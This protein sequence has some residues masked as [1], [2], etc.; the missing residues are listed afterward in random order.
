[1]SYCINPACYRQNADESATCQHCGSSLILN[2]HYRVQHRLNHDDRR[3]TD[4]YEVIHLE[5]ASTHILK[6]LTR[7]APKLI[8]LFHREAQ[9]LET[10]SYPN[11]PSVDIDGYFRY[12]PSNS[13]EALP[14]L[15]IEKIEGV[16]LSE[17][18]ASGRILSAEM[19]VDW[20]QQM[21]EILHYL[22]GQ[23]FI[24][25]DIK[26][27]NIILRPNGQLAL[28]DFGAVRNC[29]SSTYQLKVSTPLI[30][31]SLPVDSEITALV[32]PGYTPPE[33]ILGRAVQ[34]S[35]FFALGRTLVHLCT[36]LSPVHLIS[37]TN[38]NLLDWHPHAKHLDP[39][40]VKYL[41]ELM[42]PSVLKRPKSSEE[43]LGFLRLRLPAQRKWS[44]LAKSKLFRFVC[45]FLT[46]LLLISGLHFAQRAFAD[47]AF[48]TGLKQL[49]SNRLSEA[50]SNFERS[51]SLYPTEDAYINLGYLCERTQDINCVRNS[52]NKAISLNPQSTAAYF[53][54]GSVY[55]DEWDYKSAIAFYRKAVAVSQH[56]APAPLNNLSR[57][58][59]LQGNYIEAKSLVDSALKLKLSEP[60]T[61]RP[62]LLKNLGWIYFKEKKYAE[63]KKI[64]N[65]SIDLSFNL[66]SSHCL[67]AQV[68]EVQ[69]QPANSEWRYC[70][71]IES[72]DTKNI[73]VFQWRSLFINRT[74]SPL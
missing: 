33:Q 44:K 47:N 40:L 74:L 20:L 30:N 39:P 27:S 3:M 59:I 60:K 53:N 2:H 56:T 67:L 14:C 71:T 69:K 57:L 55:E 54:L 32:T 21:V 70:L 35:D 9:V 22:H 4:V 10:L 42:Q 6:V 15:I 72:E 36:G 48:I 11:I 50:Q 52:Y 13:T 8:E 68:L 16:S 37:Q 58:L 41:D 12:L 51:I 63:A 45:L 24:H 61:V 46:V 31:G 28:I 64:L 19:A 17:W 73:E 65:Q 43:I 7:S 1:M 5:L 29:S 49:N 23:N 62:I 34:Q 18:A 66:A 25:R 38:P 26:P